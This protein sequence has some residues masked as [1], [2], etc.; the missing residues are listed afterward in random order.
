MTTVYAAMQ[1][2]YV[3]AIISGSLESHLLLLVTKILV[4]NTKTQLSVFNLQSKKF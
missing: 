2:A 4:S 1:L 3:E